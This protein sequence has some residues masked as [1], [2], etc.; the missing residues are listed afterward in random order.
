MDRIGIV[1]LG[2]MGL[3]IAQVFAQA[4]FPVRATDGA[5]GA[6]DSARDRLL[7]GLAPRIQTGKLTQADADAMLARIEIVADPGAIGPAALIVEAIA[8]D[9]H[10]KRALLALLEAGQDAG[11]IL[12]SN[13]SSLAI[14]ALARGMVNP[15]RLVG[16]HFFNPPVAMK[17]VELAGHA[18]TAP[19]A[20]A[21]ARDLA[22]RAGK[23]VITC[24]DRPGFAV[25]RCARPFYG[26]ALAMV[27]EG[28]TPSD[29]DAAMLAAGYRMGPFQLIDLI[30]ADVHLAATESIW[31]AMDCHPRYHVFDRLIERVAAGELGRKAGRGFLWPDPPGP[32]P[33]IADMIVLRIEAT[34]ANEAASLAAEGAVAAPD[35]DLAMRL[36]MNFPRGPFEALRRHGAARVIAM[37][38]DLERSAPAHL[39]GRY[40]PAPNLEACA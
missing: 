39:Q 30:G 12:A 36:G 3:G 21:Q 24:A 10:A 15:S 9:I 19:D 32:A 35:I 38:N 27:E 33:D 14:G 23:V 16:L 17:L 11:C 2:A 26:E 1:G 4:G 28:L 31:R 8:E 25:N 37:L 5:A 34:L 20:L 22:E 40:V 18:G 6:R 13:T 29:I 7:A